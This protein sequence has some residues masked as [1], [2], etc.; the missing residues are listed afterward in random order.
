MMGKNP[1]SYRAKVSGQRVAHG[2]SGRVIGAP[3]RT[4]PPVPGSAAAPTPMPA[5]A[6]GAPLGPQLAPQIPV[7]STRATTPINGLRAGKRKT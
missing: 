6:Q 5:Q 3:N 2:K 7:D 4:A 1:A